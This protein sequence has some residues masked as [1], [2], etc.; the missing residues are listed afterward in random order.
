MFCKLPF[1]LSVSVQ[2][3]QSRAC[4][5]PAGFK[6]VQRQCPELDRVPAGGDG[7]Q[8][9]SCSKWRWGSLE[10]DLGALEGSLCAGRRG[11]WPRRSEE[12]LLCPLSV[13]QPLAS[14]C[15]A[16]CWADRRRIKWVNHWKS[17]PDLAASSPN[18]R[19]RGRASHFKRLWTSQWGVGL[20]THDSP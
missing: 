18:T 4:V 12:L 14:L 19:A 15:R 2:V 5:S 7:G 10:A 13:I 17:N 3:C 9:S 11:R 1:P 6:V 20:P 16:G 8:R